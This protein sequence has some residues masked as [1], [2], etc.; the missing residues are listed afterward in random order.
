M[1]ILARK[2]DQE[3]TFTE[4]AWKILGKNKNGWEQVSNSVAKNL[5]K[6]LAKPETGEVVEKAKPQ[7]ATN[8]LEETAKEETPK[9]A[10]EVD[11]K[12]EFIS[13]VKEKN[14]TKNQIKDYLDSKE[15]SFKAGDSL[16]KLADVL[17]TALNGDIA[18]LDS[19]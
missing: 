19:L 9:E 18:A 3:K 8:S 15:I 11:V 14:I 1:G 10:V 6:P 2:G 16:D 7:T 17:Y 13:A 5:A 12:A 4:T